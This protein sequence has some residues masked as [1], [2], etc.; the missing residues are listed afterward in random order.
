[1]KKLIDIQIMLNGTEIEINQ[2]IKTITDISKYE[3]V[4]S[5]NIFEK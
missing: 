5:F 2:I 4:V 1:M 3:E